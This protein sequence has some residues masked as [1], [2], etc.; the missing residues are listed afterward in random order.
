MLDLLKKTCLGPRRL[1][2]FNHPTDEV[3]VL[4]AFHFENLVRSEAKPSLDR[5]INLKDVS[6]DSSGCVAITR[7][8]KHG[9]THCL[10]STYI[11]FS[12]WFRT[13]SEEA[14]P[15]SRGACDDADGD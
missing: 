10:D 5:P 4:P 1:S 9:S 14:R 7:G 8:L 3:D 11:L 13:R 2:V 6:A 12:S 15:R